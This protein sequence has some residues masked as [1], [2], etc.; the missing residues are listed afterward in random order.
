MFRLL[1]GLGVVVVILT[2]YAVVD[3]ALF[4][5]NR[6]RGVPRWAWIL[7]IILLPVLGAVLW[8][9]IGRGRRSNTANP[10][11]RVTRSMAPDDDPDFLRGLDRVKDQDQRIRDLEQELADFDKM[12][13]PADE[14]PRPGT[15]GVDPKKTEPG[16]GDQ[17]GRRDA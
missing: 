9:V 7:M 8:L 6:I 5:R 16:E 17:P 13:P 14:A 2:V 4:D 11:G 10:G 12:D 15:A 3:C 1:F